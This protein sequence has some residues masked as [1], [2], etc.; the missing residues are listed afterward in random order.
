M[1]SRASYRK[2]LVAAL[3]FFA[4]SG[5]FAALWVVGRYNITIWPFVCGFR[6]VYG[7]PCPTCGYT[8]SVLAFTQG[9]VIRSFYVQPA[10]ALFCSLMV[11][12]AF[13]AFLVAVFGVYSPA[14]ERR[15][16]TLKLRYI[17]A[18]LAFVVVAGWIVTFVRTIRQ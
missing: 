10:A 9:Q 7:L 1:F 6:Q 18:A 5:S 2:R 16:V 14:F 4:I 3:V 11:S 13:F 17:F 15:I 12:A 8:T